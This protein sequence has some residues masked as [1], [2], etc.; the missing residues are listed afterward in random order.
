MRRHPRQAR[1]QERVNQILDVA[2]QMFI[3]EG[4]NATTTNAIAAKANVSIGSLYQFFPDKEAIVQAL[5]SRYVGVL[6]QRFD[7]LHT[8]ETIHSSLSEYV[9]LIVDAAEQFFKDYPGYHAIFTQVQD[10]IPELGKIESAADRQLIQDWAIVLSK[11]YPGLKP[12]D[13]EAIAFTL[14]NAIGTLLWLSLSQQ[15]SFRQRLV[16]ETKRM[17]LGYLQSY[18]PIDKVPPN[19]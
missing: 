12:A 6:Q 10:A 4:Y 5:T 1:S 7:T 3:A 2:E 19:K 15:G 9:E 17:M 11:Y 8:L 18:F 14:V 16:A 13:Y